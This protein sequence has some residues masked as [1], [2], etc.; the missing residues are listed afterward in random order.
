MQKESKRYPCLRMLLAVIAL[1]LGLQSVSFS[2]EA[3]GRIEGTVTDQRGSVIV[4]AK[5]TVIN[6]ATQVSREAITDKEGNY[7]A[8]ALPLG[9]YR[10]T[11][12]REGFKKVVSDDKTLQI[13][14][15]LRVDP[16]LEV[17]ASSE[18]V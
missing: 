16:V 17:G 2:Q 5:I 3:T 18:S 15:V 9:T 7:Q 8:L 4:G 10:I 11:A 1:L 14:Q 6:I 13:N 12:E